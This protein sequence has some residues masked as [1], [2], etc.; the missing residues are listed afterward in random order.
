MAGTGSVGAIGVSGGGISF[1][2]GGT[3]T[4]ATKDRMSFRKGGNMGSPYFFPKSH[5][6]I[7][8]ISELVNDML[9]IIT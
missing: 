6:H 5:P 4:E 2:V 8:W 7:M 3:M 1:R 9:G